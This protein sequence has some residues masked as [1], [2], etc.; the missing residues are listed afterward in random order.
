MLQS[1]P[2]NGLEGKN[3]WDFVQIKHAVELEL[4]SH[5]KEEYDVVMP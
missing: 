2:G 5:N 4:G 3:T 1:Y